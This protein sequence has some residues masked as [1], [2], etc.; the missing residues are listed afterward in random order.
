MLIDLLP[1]FYRESYE[2]NQIQGGLDGETEKLK[3]SHEDFLNQLFVNTATWGL[4]YWEKYLGLEVDIN[5]PYEFRRT[6]IL[7]KLRGK[8]TATVKMIKNVAESFTNGSVDVIEHTST[9]SFEVKFIDVLGAPPNIQDLQNAIDEIKPAHLSVI[10]SYRYL[11]I[12]HVQSL[13]INELQSRKLSDF[14]P[15]IPVT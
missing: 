5:K 12:A 6:R 4:N 1:L 2:V 9:Y 7:S 14:A 3:A 11:T 15:F 8:G 13:T 10:Y